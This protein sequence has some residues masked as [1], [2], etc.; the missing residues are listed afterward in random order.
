MDA[1]SIGSNQ[2]HVMSDSGKPSRTI[3]AV[4]ILTSAIGIVPLLM[5][6]GILPHGHDA[7][8]PTPPWVI[9]LVGQ[10]FLCAGIALVMKGAVG[11][12]NDARLPARAPRLLRIAYDLMVIVIVCSLAVLVTWV[13]FG[14]G[15]RHFSV[16]GG[17]LSMRTSGAGDTLG[18]VAFGFGSVLIWCIAGAIVVTMVRRWRR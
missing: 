9:W 1:N 16:S 18:R 13:A 6:L 14:P 12:A 7:S 2:V 11:S 4:G 10:A 5:A 17:G 8:D 15:A 3:I